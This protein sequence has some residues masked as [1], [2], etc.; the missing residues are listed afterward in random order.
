MKRDK[1]RKSLFIFLLLA[2]LVI[3][4]SLWAFFDY[5]QITTVDSTHL[6]PVEFGKK[7]IYS[8]LLTQWPWNH[9]FANET[10]RLTN[11]EVSNLLWACQGE[12]RPGF[13]V[14]PSAGATYPLDLFV[15]SYDGIM[16]FLPAFSRYVP[17]GHKLATIEVLQSK[18]DIIKFLPPNLNRTGADNWIFVTSTIER[19]SLRYGDRA[20]R[21]IDLEVGHLLENLRLESWSRNIA[22]KLWI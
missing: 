1:N 6:P 21:Y 16:G 4:L 8:G 5:S 11:Q 10:K 2:V 18:D 9:T 22:I 14:V 12:N 3:P 19:T 17:S 15:V 13:R 7:S 20:E